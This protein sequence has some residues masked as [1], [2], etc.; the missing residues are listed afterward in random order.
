MVLY[1]VPAAVSVADLIADPEV[2][3]DLT[4]AT[5]KFEVQVESGADD[6]ECSVRLLDAL[7]LEVAADTT[8]GKFNIFVSV[9]LS[10]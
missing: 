9:L 2:G 1:S 5:L 7:G 4:S 3:E 10:F 8:G 6:A